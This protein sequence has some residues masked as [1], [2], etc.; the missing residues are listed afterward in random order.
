MKNG[1]KKNNYFVKIFIF[2]RKKRQNK[3]TN[4]WKFNSSF[5]Y[6]RNL[7]RSLIKELQATSLFTEIFNM[8]AWNFS[9]NRI[10]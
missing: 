5:N 10:Q 3:D 4:A 7:I 6:I 2:Y 1:K 8:K 9:L